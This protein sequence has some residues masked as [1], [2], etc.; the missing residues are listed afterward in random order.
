MRWCIEIIP[1]SQ[2]YLSGFTVN[3]EEK[4]KRALKYSG[5]IRY[6]ELN[7]SV[8]HVIVGNPSANEL[9]AMNNIANK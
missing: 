1:F 3:E 8:T 6:T 4:L 9:E 7:E 5:A 2:V